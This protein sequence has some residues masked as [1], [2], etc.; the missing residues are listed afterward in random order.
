MKLSIIV[1]AYNGEISLEKIVDQVFAVN[2]GNVEIEIIISDDGSQDQTPDLIQKHQ[3]KYPGLI[4]YTSP[5]ILGKH[6]AVRLGIA[7]STGE[8]IKIQDAD[9]ELDPNEYPRLLTRLLNQETKIVYGSKF[10]N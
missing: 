9:L 1:P 6:A 4:S 2:H 7:I 3:R 8:I 10:L 5:T